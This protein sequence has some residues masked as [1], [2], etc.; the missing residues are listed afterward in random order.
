MLSTKP[1]TVFEP[2][3]QKT[4][5]LHMPKQMHISFAVTAKLISAFVF[6][7]QII[8]FL[9]MYFQNPNFSA[10]IYLLCL[11]SSVCVRPVRKPDCWFAS[12]GAH[13]SSLSCWKALTLNLSFHFDN[14]QLHVQCLKSCPQKVICSF[15]A[16][17]IVED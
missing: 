6:V 17:F 1:Q 3:H 13:L 9:Y 7:K 14:K 11:Y 8:Q 4:Y 10:P 16:Y 15:L 5:N 12:D 2:L